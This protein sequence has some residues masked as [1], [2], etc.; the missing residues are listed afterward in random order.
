MKKSTMETIFATLTAINFD[1]AEIMNELQKEINRGAELK[2][3]KANEYAQA[4]VAVA[5]T[6]RESDAPMTIAD[7][8]AKC[9]DT[10]PDGFTKAKVQYGLTHQWVDA[11]T[12]TEGKVNSY[13]LRA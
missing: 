2:A 7:I 13:S 9:A 1:N 6:L 8:Y 10:L 11:I 3:Q 12:K 5:D 4:W